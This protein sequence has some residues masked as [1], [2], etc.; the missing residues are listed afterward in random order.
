MNN[1]I[2][3]WYI[4]Y[5]RVDHGS[6]VRWITYINGSDGLWVTDTMGQ[7]GHGSPKVSHGLLW[8]TNGCYG[9]SGSKV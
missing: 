1:I 2:A 7:E 3:K 9:T 5:N 6:W 4:G 8:A